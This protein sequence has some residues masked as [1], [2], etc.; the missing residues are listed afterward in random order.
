MNNFNPN[1]IDHLQIGG[2]LLEY[3]CRSRFVTVAR[4]VIDVIDFH[5]DGMNWLSTKGMDKVR[6]LFNELY[7]NPDTPIHVLIDEDIRD[8]LEFAI[9][10]VDYFARDMGLNTFD[11]IV[12]LVKDAEE[13]TRYVA[14][15]KEL[16]EKGVLFFD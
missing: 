10:E 3:L 1:V 13:R 9:D 12:K 4:L 11:D 15:R 7:D 5:L 16:E 6:D 14:S 2:K 8:C